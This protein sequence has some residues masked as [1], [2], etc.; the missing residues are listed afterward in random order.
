MRVF[1]AKVV[2]EPNEPEVFS[3]G[4]AEAV[5]RDGKRLILHNCQT[6]VATFVAGVLRYRVIQLGDIRINRALISRVPAPEW[7]KRVV[8]MDQATPLRDRTTPALLSPRGR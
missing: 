7:F 5:T 8:D 3:T 1:F 4:W 6:C 2:P